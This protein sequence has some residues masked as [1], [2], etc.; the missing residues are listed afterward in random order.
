MEEEIRALR[1]DGWQAKFIARKLGL[2]T[3][4]V[5]AVLRRAAVAEQE[6]RDARGELPELLECVTDSFCA[7]W[8]LD[9]D[10]SEENYDDFAT[11]FLGLSH[12]LV[13]RRD[14]GKLL[15]VDFLVD[16]WCLGAKNAMGPRRADLWEY[17]QMKEMLFSLYGPP[18]QITLEQA[19]AIVYGAIDFARKLGF[20]PHQ[21]TS[22]ALKFLGPR[23]ETLL[24]LSYGK[25]GKPVFING[26][27]DDVSEVMQTLDASVGK[28]NYGHLFISP[29]DLE[30]DFDD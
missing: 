19:Q 22:A 25:A 24:P 16:Y 12:I 3:G 10:Q 1:A 29:L 6:E 18:Q 9:G 15:S 5:E 30:D 13:T 23:P 28:G 17:K 14:R 7:R 26:P 20:E 11:E 27:D 21:D 8:L 4:E 2:R